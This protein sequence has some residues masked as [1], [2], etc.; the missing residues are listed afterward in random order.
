VA[1]FVVSHDNSVS[2]E[3]SPYNTDSSSLLLFSVNVQNE[4]VRGLF[5]DKQMNIKQ[6]RLY[7]NL[8]KL[9]LIALFTKLNFSALCHTFRF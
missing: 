5:G 8:I 9:N 6:T 4:K 1:S 7:W 2:V 3:L